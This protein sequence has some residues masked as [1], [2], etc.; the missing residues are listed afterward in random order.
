[1]DSFK[2]DAVATVKGKVLQDF[3]S[4]AKRYCVV[5]TVIKILLAIII[6]IAYFIES[7]WLIELVVLAV[8]FS[9]LLPLGFYGAFIENLIEYNTSTLED[10]V[11]LNANEANEA[12]TKMHEKVE[13][14]VTD[15]GK[16]KKDRM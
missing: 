13:G 6:A 9:L 8:V 10:R 15:I 5:T 2:N 11:L 1:M 12:L 14:M 16:L 7:S 4:S 3:V